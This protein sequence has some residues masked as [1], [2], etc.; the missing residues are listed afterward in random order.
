MI[1]VILGR[2]F[3][4]GVNYIKISQTTAWHSGNK[5]PCYRG[6]NFSPHSLQC[7][8]LVLRTASTLHTTQRLLIF[9]NTM[10]SVFLC[11]CGCFLNFMGSCWEASVLFMI[12]RQ[13]YNNTT[14]NIWP[15]VLTTSHWV[16]VPLVSDLHKLLTHQIF[17][18]RCF[19]P[20]S[21]PAYTL[22]KSFS[23]TTSLW[24]FPDFPG[25]G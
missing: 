10:S 3:W 19:S 2:F 23:S 13:H 7:H 18:N 9:V 16:S 5:H 21:S 4:G 6:L 24:L 8:A 1:F 11:R 25:L 17:G 15:R 20:L 12:R 22:L 14:F